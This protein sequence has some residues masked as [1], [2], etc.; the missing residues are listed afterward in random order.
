MNDLNY[1][2][3]NNKA[4]KSLILFSSREQ[5]SLA[6]EHSIVLSRAI[7]SAQLKQVDIQ[8]CHFENDGSFERMLAGCSRADKLYVK[9]KHNWQCAPVAALL[10]NPASMLRRICINFNGRRSED[11][12]LS[13]LDEQATRDMNILGCM[14]ENNHLKQLSIYGPDSHVCWDG[15]KFDGLLCDVTSIES[16]SSNS[17]HTLECI[18]IGNHQ[19][20][21]TF[22]KKCL[23]LN[24]NRDKAKVIRKK[25][26]QVFF[27]GDFDL[28]P[29]ACMAVS[30]LPEVVSRIKGREKLSAIY[31]LL[32]CMPDL[33]DV[34]G[35][36]VSS[37]PNWEYGDVLNWM[38]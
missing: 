23:L 3:L 7:G 35:G 1:F 16:I 12:D 17:N 15:N 37:E 38:I 19:P 28:S 33:R 18:C 9:C 27:V 20:L 34:S 32:Q 5:E 8:L 13:S 6:L 11:G 36:V 21:S 31:R 29:F 14:V 26:F 24:K 25:I 10:R 22:T 4:M 30:V 2:I